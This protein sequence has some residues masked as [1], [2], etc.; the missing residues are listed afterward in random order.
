MYNKVTRISE[1]IS[2]YNKV[3]IT[4]MTRILQTTR[5]IIFSSNIIIFFSIFP[6]LF[7]Y[8]NIVHTVLKYPKER[9]KFSR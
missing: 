6:L 8:T 2:E 4:K 7:R 1:N 9:A 5:N 3:K